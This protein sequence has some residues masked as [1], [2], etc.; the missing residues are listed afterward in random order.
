MVRRR[1]NS[2]LLKVKGFNRDWIKE[3]G[4]Q[5]VCGEC[6]SV[7]Q[8][9]SIAIELHLQNR[10]EQGYRRLYVCPDCALKIYEDGSDK[11]RLAKNQGAQG[12]I[13]FNDM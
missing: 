7:F 2:P 11:I 9:N 12:F 8:K 13:M 5:W 3:V 1:L 4:S 6:N 10:N